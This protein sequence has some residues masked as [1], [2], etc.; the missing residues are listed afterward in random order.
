LNS[1]V[2][3][4]AAPASLE[5]SIPD[6]L[7]KDQHRLKR[8]LER[9][10]GETKAGK[11]V[12]AHLND[13]Q[14]RIAESMAAR[15]ARAA[16][17]PAFD[18]PMDLPVAGKKDEILAAILKNQVVIVCGETGSGKTTQLPKICLEAGRGVSGYI[19]HTQPRRIAARSVA[20]RIA[21]ELRQPLGQAVGY[22][23]RFHDHTSP[24]SL[25]KLMTDGI[26]L[27]ET[28]HDRF[29]DQYDT[30]IIDEAHERSLNID[31]LL[32]YMKWLLPRRPDFK[33]IVTS[34][35]I[36]PV[37]FSRHFNDAP[38]IN[39][40]GRTYPVEIRYRP[41]LVE[42]D[43]EDETG[44]EL[45][46]GILA[47]VDELHRDT[48]GDILIFLIGER[49]IRET[50]E[51]LRKHHP[52]DCEILPLY[53]R[54]SVAEQDRVWN[55]REVSGLRRD[56]ECT[57]WSM[58]QL[59]NPVASKYD[60]PERPGDAALYVEVSRSVPNGAYGLTCFLPPHSG[61]FSYRVDEY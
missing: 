54:L 51:S 35:T 39:V 59:G 13:V 37:R 16:S 3:G 12:A 43:A 44:D 41:M 42:S 61:I 52:V 6:C 45:Q 47:A 17:V 23:V 9:L 7:R 33:L 29:L 26:L 40:S 25:I 2:I 14:T 1:P 5:R 10:R 31:F 60:R 24:D 48:K 53:S 27:A 57:L 36:D 46:R 8:A 15:Q 20:A 58:D 49:D 56:V 4:A 50:A 18:Y 11:D 34:A 19:G 55:V 30:L 22:K 38:I 32:G 28:Q 21:E